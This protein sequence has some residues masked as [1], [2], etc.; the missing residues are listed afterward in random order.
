MIR[1][2]QATGQSFESRV[3]DSA[4]ASCYAV[5]FPPIGARRIGKGQLIPLKMPF[6][7]VFFH[8][9][10]ASMIVLDAKSCRIASSFPVGNRDHVSDDQVKNIVRAGA[11]GVISGLLIEGSH[12]SVR[13]IFWMPWRSLLQRPPTIPW[14]DPRLIPICSTRQM[15]DFGRIIKAHTKR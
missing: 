7:R 5:P 3:D 10:S 14:T 6:D 8:R 1:T 11:D 13:T 4:A 15:I 12:E 2:P 9:A